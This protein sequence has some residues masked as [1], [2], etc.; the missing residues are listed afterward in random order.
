[1]QNG[2]YIQQISKDLNSSIEIKLDSVQRD[3]A[4]CLSVTT[5]DCIKRGCR[6]RDVPHS[7]VALSVRRLIQTNPRI[8]PGTCVELWPAWD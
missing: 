4:G 5:I 8:R 3:D 2:S 6:V 7:V 1:M